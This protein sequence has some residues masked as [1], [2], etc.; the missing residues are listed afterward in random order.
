MASYNEM[1]IAMPEGFEIDITPW[2][3]APINGAILF[4]VDVNGSQARS[5]SYYRNVCK[6]KAELRKGTRD[7]VLRR[8]WTP[9]QW[10]AHAERMIEQGKIVSTKWWGSHKKAFAWGKSNNPAKDAY[11][12]KQSTGRRDRWENEQFNQDVDALG[13]LVLYTHQFTLV[14]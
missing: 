7:Y 4:T 3:K 5:V 9:E 12:A 2:A 6:A 13:E 11:K 14:V 8:T 10:A 1:G